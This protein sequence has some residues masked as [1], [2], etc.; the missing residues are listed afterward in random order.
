M[1][2]FK[3]EHV[4]PIL[5]GRKTQTRRLGNRRW[6]VGAI[7]QCRTR[8][9]D[10]SSTFARVRILDVRRELLGAITLQ[11]AQAEGYT[12]VAEYL[13]AFERINGSA[14][15]ELPV[16]VVEFEVVDGAR[17]QGCEIAPI[18]QH[19]GPHDWEPK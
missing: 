18:G 11:D 9:L 4:A 10:S 15:P 8:M 1:I 3:T 16:W 7:R 19:T 6:K 5:E 12:M 13:T 14:P 2:L 17:C